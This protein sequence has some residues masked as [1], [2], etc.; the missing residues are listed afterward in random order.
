[1]IGGANYIVCTQQS[2]GAS[3]VNGL[4]PLS[5]QV[6]SDG[7]SIITEKAKNIENKHKHV[8]TKF[9]HVWLYHTKAL[10]KLHTTVLLLGR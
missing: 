1:M 4:L 2:K 9:H 10:E 6:T 5:R 7:G 8:N 3:G